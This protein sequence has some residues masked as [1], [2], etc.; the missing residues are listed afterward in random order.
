MGEFAEET[1]NKTIHWI[2]EAKKS[3]KS[4]N[5]NKDDFDYHRQIIKIIDEPILRL[6]LAEMLD[7]LS[8]KSEVQKQVARKQ[9]DYLNKKFNL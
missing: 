7:E 2:S 6:K 9:I 8:G 3:E 5:Q 1:I 4:F